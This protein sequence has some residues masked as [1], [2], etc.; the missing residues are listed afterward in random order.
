MAKE[1]D[2]ITIQLIG[3]RFNAATKAL[4]IPPALAETIKGNLMVLLNEKF[5]EFKAISTNREEVLESL[6]RLHV[7]EKID[8]SAKEFDMPDILEEMPADLKAQADLKDQQEVEKKKHADQIRESH[9]KYGGRTHT[10]MADQDL[11]KSGI[12]IID[13]SS[14]RR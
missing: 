13:T 9:M 8:L 5:D 12:R 10:P 1:R 4:K 14:W 7:A 2:S 3:R 11:A 6:L